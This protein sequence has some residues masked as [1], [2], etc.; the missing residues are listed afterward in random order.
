MDFTTWI[1]SLKPLTEIAQVLGGLGLVTVALAYVKH[2]VE[3]R[4]WQGFKK[5]VEHWI[6]RELE[7]DRHPRDFTIEDWRIECELRLFDSRFSPIQIEQLL[8]TAVVVAKGIA[9][10]KVFM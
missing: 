5:R 7:A 9:A 3:R 4:R 8:D 10:S 6:D 1:E 2:A